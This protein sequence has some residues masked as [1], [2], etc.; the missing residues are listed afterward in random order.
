M[1]H[2]FQEK[3]SGIQIIV[4]HKPDKD[5]AK[6]ELVNRVVNPNDWVYLGTVDSLST[7]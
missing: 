2:R 5:L 1:G 4:W 3:Y 6:R 7:N